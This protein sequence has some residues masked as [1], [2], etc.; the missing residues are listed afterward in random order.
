MPPVCPCVCPDTRPRRPLLCGPDGQPSQGSLV[1]RWS[2]GWMARLAKVNFLTNNAIK[3]DA[4]SVLLWPAASGAHLS[5]LGPFYWAHSA[6]HSPP[7]PPSTPCDLAYHDEHTFVLKLLFSHWFRDV[8]VLTAAVVATWSWSKI[9]IRHTTRETAAAE[10]NNIGHRSPV[11]SA[12][13]HLLSFHHLL[14]S[15]PQLLTPQRKASDEIIT[16]FSH[17]IIPSWLAYHIPNQ[18]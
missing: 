17:R 15:Y 5:I 6:P 11:P 16:R 8:V 10:G 3:T 13:L 4:P 14:R 18:T 2:G 9:I 7:Q 12:D 1:Y